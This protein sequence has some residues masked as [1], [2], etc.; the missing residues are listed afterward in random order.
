MHFFRSFLGIHP[1]KLT[2]NLKITCLKREII[3]HP[4]PF[5]GF[6]LDI[7]GC[8]SWGSWS[9]L[10]ENCLNWR[11]WNYMAKARKHIF[12]WSNMNVYIYIH[13]YTYMYIYIITYID[14]YYLYVTNKLFAPDLCVFVCPAS[15]GHLLGP[16]IRLP[17]SMLTRFMVKFWRFFPIHSFH[18]ELSVCFEFF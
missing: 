16:A 17:G 7:P 8:T 9:L 18:G 11:K 5:F 12:K 1:W 13:C 3:F 14:S 15:Q 4:P 10:G 2:W 6:H